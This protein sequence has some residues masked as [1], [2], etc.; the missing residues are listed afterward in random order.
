MPNIYIFY[1]NYNSIKTVLKGKNMFT[2]TIG[3]QMLS[4]S[5]GF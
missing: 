5:S 3:K 4:G 1:V 2:K